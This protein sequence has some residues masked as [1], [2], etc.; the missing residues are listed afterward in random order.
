MH[1]KVISGTHNNGTKNLIFTEKP[2]I[3]HTHTKTKD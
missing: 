1:K 3:K 2:N